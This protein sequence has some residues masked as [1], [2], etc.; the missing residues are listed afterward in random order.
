MVSKLTRKSREDVCIAITDALTTFV[1]TASSI[2]NQL[3]K[4]SK[5]DYILADET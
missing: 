5:Y 4:S 2:K 1:K 3:K